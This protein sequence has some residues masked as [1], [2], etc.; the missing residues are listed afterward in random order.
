MAFLTFKARDIHEKGLPHVKYQKLV[1]IPKDAIH[2][3]QVFI[4][5]TMVKNGEE[6]TFAEARVIKTGEETKEGYKIASG[7]DMWDSIITFSDRE[8]KDGAE[9]VI[10]NIIVIYVL[11]KVF[12]KTF[13]APV[14]AYYRISKPCKVSCCQKAYIS[15]FAV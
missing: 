12:F 10:I 8:L 6:R 5:K 2:N 7:T 13:I 1:I 15:P 11:H 3:N 9:V 14:Q 4:I